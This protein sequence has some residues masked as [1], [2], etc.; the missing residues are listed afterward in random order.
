MSQSNFNG[1]RRD[2]FKTDSQRKVEIARRHY[3]AMWAL[4]HSP[5]ID[6]YRQPA[7]FQSAV[8]PGACPQLRDNNAG[9]SM[10]YFKARRNILEFDRDGKSPHGVAGSEQ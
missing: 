9:R 7:G 2:L 3:N 5:Q 8:A 6:L 4:G 10:R 1:W